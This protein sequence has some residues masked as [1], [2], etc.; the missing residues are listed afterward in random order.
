MISP[1]HSATTTLD[2]LLSGFAVSG[3]VPRLPISGIT[4]NSRG[5]K[6][7]DLFIAQAGLT[8]H[9]ID[10]VAEAVQA[11]AVAVLYDA[12]DPYCQQRIP[13]LQK[14]FDVTW[15]ALPE[16]Q[17]VTGEIA[18]RYYGNPSQDCKLIGVTGTD[19]KTSVT[20]LLVQALVRLKQNVGSVGTLGYGIGN[21]LTMT[22]Y[23]TPDAITLQS[24]IFE[25]TR[26]GCKTLVMEVSSHALEQYR[27]SGCSF[28]IAVLTNLGSDHLDYHGT[29]QH[30]AKAKSALFEFAGLSRRVLNL[31]DE[32][33]KSLAA[34]HADNQVISY[35]TD[36]GKG[37]VADVVLLHG[38]LT[39]QGLHVSAS[40]P[41]GNVDIQSALIGRFNIDNLLA[42]IS[43]LIGLDFSV[44]QIEQA[45]QGL[46]PIP[47]RMQYFPAQSNQPAVVIDFAHTE[48]ALAACL[49]SIKDS[50]H[51]DIYCVFGCGGDRDQSKRSKMGRV[52]EQMADHVFITDDNPRH[53][54]PEA[55]V[56]DI[57]S[58]IQQPLEVRIIHDRQIAIETAMSQADNN[59]LV[60]IAG[61]GHEQIQIVGDQRLPFSDARVVRQYRHEVSA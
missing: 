15:I 34:K 58:G 14:Q 2:E 57:L 49:D 30:Y 11:G 33:G 53:E 59:D 46:Q 55:I 42:C 56:E 24:L 9:A 43:V 45:M 27:V 26:Q 3:V 35:T 22:N 39:P 38:E 12:Y 10:F 16:L 52:A 54:S 25:L 47:G 21:H 28:D 4:S 40:T 48:Q 19:G 51:G 36:S 17:K 60:L 20:H 1:T 32:F 18:S 29:R 7:D 50:C 61:K 23:T 8:R 31:K 37:P 41:L 5:V 6:K 44:E 13:L